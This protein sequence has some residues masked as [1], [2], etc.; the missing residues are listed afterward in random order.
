[1]SDSPTSS[2]PG[3]IGGDTFHSQHSSGNVKS[4]SDDFCWAR[5]FR[6]LAGILVLYLN[7]PGQAWVG[8]LQKVGASQVDVDDVLSQ[9]LDPEIQV[10]KLLNKSKS[11]HTST[12]DWWRAFLREV[13]N[14]GNE[15]LTKDV[16]KAHEKFING[17][18]VDSLDSDKS[19]PQKVE[20]SP[21]SPSPKPPSPTPSVP[22]SSQSFEVIN[23]EEV[24]KSSEELKTKLKE[25][26]DNVEYSDP[27]VSQQIEKLCRSLQ[28]IVGKGK[29]KT[30]Q[31][32]TEAVPQ[33]LQME[34]Q[35]RA[36]KTYKDILE[37]ELGLAKTQ[38]I[39][40]T[41]DNEAKS[42]EIQNLKQE[43]EELKKTKADT[44]LKDF[45]IITKREAHE[46]PETKKSVPVAS[47]AITEETNTVNISAYNDLQARC[48]KLTKQRDQLV[49]V[50]HQWDQEYHQM[51]KTLRSERQK[52][53]QEVINR[54]EEI[55]AGKRL[56]ATLEK[57]KAE[58]ERLLEQSAAEPQEQKTNLEILQ[59]KYDNEKQKCRKY[60]EYATRL[61]HQKEKL[62][63]E[64]S[65]LNQVLSQEKKAKKA[66]SEGKAHDYS[67]SED[68]ENELIVYRQ[69][70]EIF[71][72]DF[73]EEQRERRRLVG[74]L[75]AT[76]EELRE[77]KRKLKKLSDK[78][79]M[80]R[81]EEMAQ[82]LQAGGRLDNFIHRGVHEDRYT[83]GLNYAGND[84]F[85]DAGPLSSFG[86]IEADS[87]DGNDVAGDNEI[88]KCP[89]CEA[90]INDERT[91]F[92][93]LERCLNE[94]Q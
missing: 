20:Q 9:E 5:F 38:N 88:N 1:M 75:N 44:Q 13:Q 93:H 67:A 94:E 41:K 66:L 40:L 26:F 56:V 29:L 22:K 11:S 6:E 46:I 30:S 78:V 65:R 84:Q 3:A 81:D 12:T 51:E 82:K 48:I 39:R 60:H 86:S 17:E 83:G 55:M 18:V 50:N 70:A 61:S 49:K 35:F 45:D 54:D 16:E 74:E 91:F 92:Q 2:C 58:I 47:A 42:L 31:Q 59:K 68:M 23:E 77:V 28:N 36:V 62:E 25:E 87:V 89:R 72:K 63:G 53:Y 57:E 8:L 10:Y 71:E 64:I 24:I 52:L 4:I 21:T 80:A 15:Q 69:Q 33:I 37:H 34:S 7:I 27:E 32:L 85:V 19:I 76:K 79:Q 14:I 43:I 73:K 90:Q